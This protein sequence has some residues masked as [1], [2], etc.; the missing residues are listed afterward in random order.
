MC[1]RVCVCVQSMNS[2]FKSLSSH[3][4][5]FA[6]FVHSVSCE[7]SII[8]TL[9]GQRIPTLNVRFFV[10]EVFYFPLLDCE[11]EGGMGFEGGCAGKNKWQPNTVSKIL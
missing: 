9:W 1:V 6:A 5:Y 7:S 11:S 4:N 10:C 2:L 3:P 8:V